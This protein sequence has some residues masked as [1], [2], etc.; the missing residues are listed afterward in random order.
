MRKF[1]LVAAVAAVML[2]GTV[3]SAQQR[4][5]AKTARAAATGMRAIMTPAEVMQAFTIP[6][7]DAVFK[8]AGDQPKSADDWK[9]V[10]LQSLALAESANLLLVPGRGPDAASWNQMST[11]MMTSALSAAKAAEAKNL[12]ALDTASNDIYESCDN[13]HKKYMKK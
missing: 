6:A 9:Q 2:I 13:C 8:I 1:Q 4:S 3:L 7:S 5:A 10:R 11:A 12:D